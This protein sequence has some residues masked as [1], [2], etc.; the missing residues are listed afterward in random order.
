VKQKL[1]VIKDCIQKLLELDRK[2]Q[3][4]LK[5]LQLVLDDISD[6]LIP[7]LMN[8]EGSIFPYFKQVVSAWTKKESYGALL[9]K[10]LRK[11]YEK[12]LVQEHKKLLELLQ[13][14]RKMTHNY[15]KG[16]KSS[17]AYAILLQHLCEFDSDT[18]QHIYLEDKVLFPKIMQIEKDLQAISFSLK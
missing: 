15:D 7:K 8:E 6:A 10:T 18:Q 1:P 16:R 3:A 17:P 2:H 14:I 12:I 9:V 11:P 5:K 13:S 4:E